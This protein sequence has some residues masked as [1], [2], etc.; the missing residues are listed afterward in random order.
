[1][2]DI[3]LDVVSIAFN[4]VTIVIVLKMWKEKK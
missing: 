2:L 1:M 3:I 4:L